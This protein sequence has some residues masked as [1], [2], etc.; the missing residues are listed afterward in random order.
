MNLRRLFALAA[1]GAAILG[2]ASAR[3]GAGGPE[4][5]PP[6]GGIFQ[7]VFAP[8]EQL[9]TM[10]PAIANTQASWS[11]LDLTCARLMN[12]PDKP[13]PQAFRLVPEVAAAPPKISRDG[14]TYTFTLRHTF[15][16]SDGK[17]VDAR[18]F[19]RAIDRT[20]APGLRSLG[21]RYMEDIVGARAVQAGRATHARG[22]VA[23]GYRLVIRLA[24]PLGDLPA[25]T[26]MP[27]FCAVPPNL[28]A[29][30]EGRGVFPGSGPYH[31]T[32]YRPGQ[33]VTIKRNRYYAGTRPHH[34]AGFSADLT[35]SSPQDVL[36]RIEDG[37][38]D[39]GIIPPPL[40][41]APE[42][43]LVRKYGINKRQFFVRPGF[44]LRAF[45]M[46]TSRPLFRGNLALRKAVNY[47]LDRR[48]FGSV[49][50]ARLTDQ[51]LPP[52]LPGF[53]DAKIYPLRGP[54]LRK[55]RA[56]ASGHLRGGQAN[57]YVA[58][59]ALT[60][61]L[62]QIAKRNL[63]QIGLDVKV[64][65]I[66]PAAYDARLRTPGEPFDLAFF[67]TPSV[68]FYDPYAFLN[69]YFDSRFIGRANVSN[70][71]S[72]TFDRRL[73]AASRLRGSERLRAYGRLDADLM[74][75][76]APVAPLTYISEPTLVSKRVR[77]VL[78][79]PTLDLMTAC[80]TR[81]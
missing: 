61:G 60:I 63:K 23:R 32:E 55:A 20:L 67:V 29:D 66:P 27:F 6:R 43:D 49:P 56:L 10:D 72:P 25:R 73:R 11:L 3:P 45:M 35:G 38:A 46:N 17:P 4:S 81:R 62:G 47:A 19:A 69:L 40:Y 13:A 30:P 9:D 42:R 44:T 48:P 65:P 76:S 50:G 28:P 18:A 31:V 51:V 39:W 52:Q 33:R 58:D 22:V 80:I 64:V 70:L 12:Y 36:D 8:P 54:A 34:V 24:Q 77:C 1:V 41:F 14:K 78:L 2:L 5:K 59:L 26:S 37:R 7:I 74:R 71:R 15:R 53:R 21:T 68:D 57:L 75:R 79:R 16:F